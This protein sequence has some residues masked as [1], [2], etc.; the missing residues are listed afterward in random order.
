LYGFVSVE[1]WNVRPEETVLILTEAV[2]QNKTY[3][4]NAFYRMKHV[5]LSTALT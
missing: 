1:Q 2:A 3:L 4:V 5:E